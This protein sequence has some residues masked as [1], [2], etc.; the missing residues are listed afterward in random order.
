MSTKS[1]SRRLAA[2]QW[3]IDVLTNLKTFLT[4]HSELVAYTDFRGANEIVSCPHL[5]FEDKGFIKAL[6]DKKN[7]RAILQLER[8]V[9]NWDE[10]REAAKRIISEDISHASREELAKLLLEIKVDLSRPPFADED[11]DEEDD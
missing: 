11:G 9:T 4:Q 6:W 3:R 8:Y 1:L 10:N 2:I 5:Y 7:K